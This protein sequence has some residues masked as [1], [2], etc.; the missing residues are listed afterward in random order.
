MLKGSSASLTHHQLDWGCHNASP[1]VHVDQRHALQ[2]Q[3]LYLLGKQSP[4]TEEDMI[5]NPVKG[6]LFAFILLASHSPHHRLPTHQSLHWID[7]D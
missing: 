6:Q 3:R 2:L 1:T 5:Q 4:V 7:K